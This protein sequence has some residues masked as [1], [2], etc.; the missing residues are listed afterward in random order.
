M[1][2]GEDRRFEFGKNW[3]DFIQKHFSAEAIDIS[4][5]H[6]LKFM[7]RPNL[8]DLGVLDIGCGSGLHSIA[9]LRAGAKSVHCFDYDANSVVTT[10]YLR[11]LVGKPAN[12]TVEQGSVLDDAFIERLPLYDLV[13]SWGVLHHT[14]EVWRAIRNAASRVKPRGLFYI[15]LYS[16]DVHVDPTAEFWLAVKRRYVSSGWM[17]RRLMELW[18]IYRFQL[19]R[20]LLNLPKFLRRAREY[21]KNRGMNYYIDIRDW[22]GG[23]P[24]EFVYDQEAI[25][26]CNKLGFKLMEIATGQANTE[27]LFIR[28]ERPNTD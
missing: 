27:F 22:L 28:G 7:N 2:R 18:Y 5:Q 15:A 12:W 14:G 4:K 23:W 3:S 11:E 17:T 13:Y 1:K 21:K 26:F 6:I 16:A 8:N 24:M 9:M 20:N 25:D 19:D 10:R